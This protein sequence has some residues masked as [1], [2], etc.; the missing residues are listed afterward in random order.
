MK[1]ILVIDSS[2]GGEES[3]SRLLVQ[4]AVQALLAAHPDSRVIRRDLGREP[5]PHLTEGNLAG[6]QGQ[7]ATEEQRA[8]RACSMH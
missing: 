6:M 3:V 7:S 5:V 2:A 1:T 4:E 8:T